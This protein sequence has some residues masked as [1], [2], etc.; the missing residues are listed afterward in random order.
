M[1][2]SEMKAEPAVYEDVKAEYAAIE[3]AFDGAGD[4]AE[5]HA[6]LKRWDDLRRSI[7]TW[8]ALVHVHFTLDTRVEANRQARE[9]FDRMRPEL[10]ELK[11][12]FMKKLLASEHRADVEA[13]VG[14]YSL[15][16]WEAE[17]TTF[18]PALKEDL[19]EESELDAKYTALL[20][21]AEIELRGKSYNLSTIRRFMEAQERDLRREADGAVWDWFG[22]NA[23]ELDAIF[24]SLVKLR[25]KMA[26]KLGFEN[27]IEFS[28]KRMARTDYGEAEVERWREEI[29]EHVVPVATRIRERQAAALG[30]EKLRF[31]D[32]ALHDPAGNPKPKGDPDWMVAQAQEVFDAMGGGLGEFYAMMVKRGLLDLDSRDGK[33]GGGYCSSLTGYGVPFIFANFNGTKDDVRVFTHEMGHAF[34]GYSSRGLYP[35][36]SLWPTAEACEIH[37]M[38]LEYLSWPQMEAFFDDD[39]DRFRRLHLTGSLLFLPYGAAIDHFQHLIY[40]DPN[41]TPA[42]RH[43]MWK[44]ME[45]TYLPWRDYDGVA[46]GE[47]GALW[48]RQLHV[49][50]HPFYYIDYTL[51]ESCALQFWLRSREDRDKAMADYVALCKRGGEAAFSDLVKGAD[52]ASPFEPGALPAVVDEAKRFLG[53]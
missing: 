37:S 13:A 6:A 14:G 42:E 44:R 1:H 50:H 15:A 20:A 9:A 22:S 2:F 24:D 31:F 32:E 10:D 39:A 12:A 40:Q 19:V 34:Q 30:V 38:S 29:R 8:G 43:S 5:R 45:Q 4:V 36:D 28:Y 49:Y 7:E 27:A 53:L 33:A 11:I 48:Q 26:R 25:D 41:A 52:L 46:H 23:A 47:R 3:A 17:I 18:H 16:R 21:S 51:A 35:I